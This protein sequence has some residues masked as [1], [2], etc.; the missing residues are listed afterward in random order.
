M[1]FRI[2]TLL[3]AVAFIA[4]WLATLK[5]ELVLAHSLRVS[6][7]TMVV[8]ISLVAV[9]FSCGRH[10]AFFTGMFVILA[11]KATRGEW[12]RFRPVFDFDYRLATYLAPSDEPLM[13]GLSATIDLVCTLVLGLICGLVAVAIYDG[14]HKP[15]SP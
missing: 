9:L 11:M 13:A 12:L 4:A 14:S 1:K 3:V 2:I 5:L 7:W 15:N 10:R 6:L 8:A